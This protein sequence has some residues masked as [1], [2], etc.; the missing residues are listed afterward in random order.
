[1]NQ[2]KALYVGTHNY[3]DMGNITLS[4][5]NDVHSDMRHFS[6]IKWSEVARKAIIKKI[7]TLK[8][9]ERLAKKSKL[10]KKDVDEFAKLIKSKAAKKLALIDH[11]LR[12]SE[13]TEK[14]AEILGEKI[15]RGIAKRHNIKS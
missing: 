10:T 4:I 7:K 2:P 12:N 13:F 5:P 1:M 3:V 14:D 9:A 11:L 6:E 8:L 15:K